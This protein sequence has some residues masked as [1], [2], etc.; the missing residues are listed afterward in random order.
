MEPIDGHKAF[1]EYLK[2]RLLRLLAGIKIDVEYHRG[3][4][5]F[6]YYTDEAGKERR[7]LDMLGGYGASLLGHNHPE[8]VARARAVLD[9]KRPFNAQASVRGQAGLL[10]RRLSEAVG[11]STGRSYVVTLANSGTEAIEAA[12]KHAELEYMIRV[13]RILE[14]LKRTSKDA[15]RR[16]NAPT[17]YVPEAL[18]AQAAR[19]FDIARIEDLDE[20]I[21][22]VFRHNLDAINREPLFLALEGAFHGKSTGSLKLTYNPDYRSPWRRIGL[23]NVFLP[24]GDVKALAREMDR[25]R[26]PY[27]DLEIAPDGAI[28]L[29]EKELV[30]ISACF[31]EPIQGEGGIR[32]VPPD[33]LLALRKA[34]DTGGFPL[35]MDEIQ[36]GMGRTGTFLASEPSGVRGDYYVL[37]KALGGGLAKISALLV[38]KERYVADYGYLHTSTFADDDFSSAMAIQ[39]LDVLERDGGA[40]MRQCREKGDYLLRRLREVAARYPGEL[41][42]VRGRGLMVGIEL[43]R[44]RKS[45]S[46]L[47]RVLSEQNL[48]GFIASGHLLHEAGVRVAP[49]LSSH[50][51]IRMEPS[52]Y[53]ETA[54]IDRFVAALEGFLSALKASDGYRAVR[55]LV[56]RAGDEA[57]ERPPRQR[58]PMTFTRFLAGMTKFSRNVAFLGHFLEPKELKHWDPSLSAFNDADCDAFLDRT[59]GLLDPFVVERTEIQSITGDTVNLTVI[60]LAF[61]PRQVMDAFAEGNTRW[62]VSLIEKGVGLAKRLGCSV[63][64]FGGYTSILTDNCRTIVEDDITVTSG[65]SL[66]SGAAVEALAQAAKKAGIWPG[67]LGVLG[68]A[69][70]IGSVLAQVAA[71]QV[72]DILLIGRPGAARRLEEAAGEVYFEAWKRLT[73][74]GLAEGLS[75]VIAETE[76][77]RR[78][79]R[80]GT[81]GVERIGDAIRVGLDKELGELAPVRVA[82]DLDA[83][84][85]CNLILTATNSPRPVIFPEHLGKGRV[86]ICDV[87]QPRDVDPSVQKER[88]DVVV[89]EGGIVRAPLGQV[90]D[91][92]GMPLAAGQVYGCMAESILLGFAGIGEDYS[93]GRLTANRVRWIRELSRIHGFTIEEEVRR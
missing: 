51:T 67:R 83:L 44:Q 85:Q 13:D 93:Y 17:A 57:K 30:N 1:G 25:A 75:A 12:I 82:A 34:A 7:V 50:G 89:L 43:A 90:L 73:R 4:G 31:V 84:K 49:A 10:A 28:A 21:V 8:L 72:R 66:T 62:A 6:L 74:Y 52:A 54:E 86:V 36:S 23:R 55:Y 65:N 35:V 77:V 79:R 18:F 76:T 15:R 19:V 69:G 91:V 32:E 61:T 9:E 37:S 92:G 26:V 68:A 56:G 5:D 63:V 64:G 60:G 81:Q 53:I 16:V 59:R 41:R 2:P 88:P 71:D 78:L 39:A 80:E 14:R 58:E 47:I 45:A 22:R 3:E 38:E 70:N 33:Y 48:L 11:R 24:I 46:P 87:A 42:D 20:L 29:V 27:L 40:L